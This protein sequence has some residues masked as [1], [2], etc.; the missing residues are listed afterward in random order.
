MWR[1]LTYLNDKLGLELI[2]SQVF[3][4]LSGVLY[5]CVGS[6]EDMICNA[7]FLSLLRPHTWP[8]NEIHTRSLHESA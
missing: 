1:V 7:T 6:G 2:R 4:Q 8:S 5:R 3:Y